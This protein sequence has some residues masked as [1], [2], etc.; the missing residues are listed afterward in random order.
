MVEHEHLIKYVNEYIDIY[1][2]I[3]LHICIQTDS[4]INRYRN[5]YGHNDLRQN[6]IY[7]TVYIYIH[8]TKWMEEESVHNLKT[9]YKYT[10]MDTYMKG[11]VYS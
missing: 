8:M 4:Y 10:G 3:H 9:K 7:K 11:H 6:C 5:E 1:T 2:Y